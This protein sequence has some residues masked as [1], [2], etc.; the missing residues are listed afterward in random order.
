MQFSGENNPALPIQRAFY[1]NHIRPFG[2]RHTF[3]VF[4][5]PHIMQRPV[6]RS[7]TSESINIAGYPIF[8][9]SFG[10]PCGNGIFPVFISSFCCKRRNIQGTYQLA[11]FVFYPNGILAGSNAATLEAERN[12]QPFS[13]GSFFRIFSVFRIRSGATLQADADR[14]QGGIEALHLFCRKLPVYRPQVLPELFF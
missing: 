9:I 12:L 11:R 14:N 2:Y 3:I 4:T 7:G 1:K 8:R 13:C 5:I 6:P 10:N